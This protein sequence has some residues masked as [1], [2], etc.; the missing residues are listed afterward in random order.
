MSIV[1]KSQ[2]TKGGLLK[3]VLKLALPI[4]LQQ[5]LAASFHLV[6]TAMVVKLGVI[7]I[8]ALGVSGRWFFLINLTFFGFA[9]GM[10][11]LVSQ[12]WG[13]KDLKNIRKS[14]S[15]GLIN[16]M[17]VG[18]VMTVLLFI[19][20]PQMLGVFTNDPLV[21]AAGTKYLKIACWA[22]LP[23]SVAFTFSYLLRSTETVILPLITTV[24]SVACN[25]ALNYIF[26]FGKLG[27]P[28][29]GIKGAAIATLISAT[30]QMILLVTISHIKKNVAA[31][32][33]KELLDFSRDFVKKYY[34][35]AL[36]VL[37]NEVM[38]AIGVSVYNMVFGRL[39][40]ENYA[41]FTI[42]SSIEQLMFTF[43][44]GICSACAVIVGKMVGRGEM[45]EAYTTAKKFM[46]YGTGLAFVVGIFV[47]LFR[48]PI[49]SLLSVPDVYTVQ[50]VSKL[51]FIYAFALPLYILP[52]IAIVGIFRSGGD[53]KTGL[54]YD[55][56]NVWFIGVPIVAIAGF[57]LKLSFEW[58]FALMWTEHVVKTIMCLVYFK[59]KKWIRRLTDS[60]FIDV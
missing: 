35:L 2:N 50:M 33:I 3:N 52:F 29:M 19:F 6:D 13:I 51:L 58:V 36:P 47:I 10:S 42:Y 45:K 28:V 54:V 15:M 39:G 1:I 5:M 30:L 56:I 34:I 37:A 57:V 44:I 32:K 18:S 59:S 16:S 40:S 25:T 26:I 11:V 21:I 20:T 38:W 14:F 27:F 41:A 49:I 22:F 31:A 53:T 46:I 48:N 17:V 9:S 55:V 8:A 24:I 43:F 7:P 60:T 4:S 12:Y 23:T